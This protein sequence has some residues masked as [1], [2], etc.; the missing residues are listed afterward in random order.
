VLVLVCLCAL[1]FQ[2]GCRGKANQAA[3]QPASTQANVT[4]RDHQATQLTSAQT[5]VASSDTVE[6]IDV[7]I[8]VSMMPSGI[9]FKISDRLKS[10][11]KK[12]D[13]GTVFGVGS[14]GTTYVN[15]GK[16]VAIELKP[17]WS[18]PPSVAGAKLRPVK[19]RKGEVGVVEAEIYVREGTEALV[20]GK[21]YEFLIKR[22]TGP[23]GP[24]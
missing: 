2:I 1:A 12:Y 18:E 23:V 13:A 10:L 6:A 20:G 16:G 24:K 15:K 4:S 11:I 3:T 19:F 7:T 22:W 8:A 14:A 5:D 17:D 9:P 21:I